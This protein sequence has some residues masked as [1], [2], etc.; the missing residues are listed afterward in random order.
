MKKSLRFAIVSAILIAAHMLVPVGQAHPLG[1][2]T[3][4]HYA[5]LHVSREAIFVEYILDMAE[6]PAFQEIDALDANRNGQAE[7]AETAGYDAAKCSS[8][9]PD[10]ELRLDDRLVA[11]E[12]VSSAL[13]FPPGVAGLPTLRLTCGFRALLD[14]EE[15]NIRATFRNNAYPKRLGWRE[16]VVVAEG[17]SLNGDFPTT[18]LSDR[19][20]RYPQDMLS[21]PLDQRMIDFEIELKSAPGQAHPPAISEQI[22][23]PFN[24]RNDAFT[25]LVLLEN[26]NLPTLLLALATAFIWGALHALTPG[27]GKTIV[28][29]YLVGSR[30]S[31][32]HALYLGLTTTITHTAGVFALGLLTLFASR[33]ILPEKVFPWLSF[34]SGLLVVGIGGNLFIHRL[35]AFG[36]EGWAR[37]TK[38]S[39]VSP[40][41]IHMPEKALLDHGHAGIHLHEHGL[42]HEPVHGPLKH[43]TH[44][45]P[46]ADGHG[47]HY[48]PKH[49]HTVEPSH[50]GHAH[51]PPGADGSPVTWR[52]LLALGISGG[53]LPCPSALVVLLS[54]IAL[55][56]TGFGL[57]LVVAFSLGLAGLLTGVGLMFV[58]AGR[59]FER[60]PMQGKILPI[61]PVISALFITLVGFGISA[62]ALVEIGFIKL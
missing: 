54:A 33:F 3:I 11:L 43:H 57:I 53:L 14:A 37:E 23:S 42:Y 46:H 28:G 62:R 49:V 61:I 5:G 20:T 35:R 18:S 41:S 12:L 10:L 9:E 7:A 30:S 32:K 60:I 34:L 59:L 58:Y 55:N 17:I 8:L 50:A 4:N 16:I 1:N 51:L 31:A 19:L 27:H 56:R 48:G 40:S 25:R 2:F 15:E 22:E 45:H 24:D 38:L 21:S 36:L 13:E 47:H 52:N 26:I 44:V 29:A 39:L 6:I